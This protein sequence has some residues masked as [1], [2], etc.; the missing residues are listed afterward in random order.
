MCGFYSPFEQAI[1]L[2]DESAGATLRSLGAGLLYKVC[3]IYDGRFLAGERSSPLRQPLDKPVKYWYTY[4]RLS[5]VTYKK[6]QNVYGQICEENYDYDAA[7]NIKC[8]QLSC[9]DDACFE[10]TANNRLSTYN[11]Y[12]VGF[13]NDGNML[14]FYKDGT[15]CS[16]TYDSSNKLLSAMGCTYTCLYIKFLNI[17]LHID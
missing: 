12:G 3:C 13:D 16:L 4:D 2:F 10:Y 7:G 6:I 17:H 14:Y 15:R 5:K 8:A 11:D 9:G 1:S